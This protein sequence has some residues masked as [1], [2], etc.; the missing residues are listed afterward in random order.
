MAYQPKS[1]KKFVATAATATL[2]ATAVVPAAFADEVKPA[3]FTDVAKQY[4]AAVN[5][6]VAN[7]IAK[8][9]NETQFGV[10]A[11]I[12]RGDAAIM[13][14][15]AAGLNNEEAPQSGFSDVPTRGVLAINSLKAAGVV[16]G[17]S[18]TNFGFNDS[19]TR[20]EA[21]IMLANAFDLDGSAENV[22]FTDVNARYLEAVAALVENEVTNGIS[23]TQFGTTN[24]IKRGDFARFLYALEEYIVP[25][26][27]PAVSTVTATNGEV[28]ATFG[29]APETAP[30][31]ADFTV[32]RSINGG[33]AVTVTPTNFEYNETTKSVSFDVPEV[34]QTNAAQTVTYSVKYKDTAAQTGSF[35]IA[36]TPASA[37]HSISANAA[38]QTVTVIFASPVSQEA[39]TTRT[40]Y[41]YDA[42][43]GAAGA[44][45][46]P[47]TVTLNTSAVGPFAA[48][49]VATLTFPAG[50]ISAADEAT[51]SLR[52]S[53]FSATAE[54]FE[55]TT[56]ANPTVFAGIVGTSD[57]TAPT[58]VSGTFELSAGAT[59]ATSVSPGT[60]V[61]V[62]F[63]ATDTETSA[64]GAQYRLVRP[65]GTRTGFSNLS[66]AD[67]A[68]DE[69]PESFTGSINTAGLTPGQYQIEVRTVNSAGVVSSVTTPGS[70]FITGQDLAAPVVTAGTASYNLPGNSAGQPSRSVTVTSSAAVDAD[71]NVA[72]A[73][74][75]V[76]SYNALAGTYTTV[77][78]WT[79]AAAND[80]AFNESSELFSFN[81]GSLAPNT[82]YR[83]QVRATDAKGNVSQPVSVSAVGTDLPGIDGERFTIPSAAGVSPTLTAPTFDA[84]R[85]AG[86]TAAPTSY[87]TLEVDGSVTAGTGETVTSVEYSI[88]KDTDLDGAYETT[89]QAFTSTGVRA[90]DGSFDE[91]AEAYTINAEVPTDGNYRVIVRA[92]NS[93]GNTTTSSDVL[94]TVID[95]TAPTATITPNTAT[96]AANDYV[97][98]FSEAVVASAALADGDISASALDEDNYTLRVNGQILDVASEVV[99]NGN[100]NNS[101]IVTFAGTPTPAAG[102]TVNVV[103]VEDIATPGNEIA[104]ASYTIR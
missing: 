85:P 41:T 45:F 47:S 66:L 1:Y 29:V 3:A 18:A 14:A 62:D 43:A 56:S 102:T 35:N 10:S 100:V 27:A 54:T 5:F 80:G 12:K 28:T 75:R 25:V 6:V 44:L 79:N 77:I 34:A 51:A 92:T 17:K 58:L 88:L 71:A 15:N 64:V 67:G 87:R 99:V 89:T 13:I 86:T 48:G 38:N 76:E 24:N 4:E 69:N 73:E 46:N 11:Q 37:V 59:Q 53:G 52:V 23:A 65:D 42:N 94:N 63:D 74:Y 61:T 70:L 49:Q 33:A 36:A 9:L 78:G 16:N 72:S 96:V 57:A 39:G 103:A 91:N 83:I 55:T 22:K 90:N 84:T 60:A 20:G 26:G 31:A 8:G 82:T 50:T 21:A 93:A 7:N 95:A 19:I 98:T 104:P 97:V 68:A 101:F 32:T 2:V 81:T 40:N 30:A